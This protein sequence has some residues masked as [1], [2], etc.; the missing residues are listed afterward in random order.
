MATLSDWLCWQLADSAFP[1]GGFAHSNG[2]EALWKQGELADTEQLSL[3]LSQAL[4]Q[5]RHADLPVIASVMREPEQM[6]LADHQVQAMNLNAVASNASRLQGR[7]LLASA[8][9]AFDSPRLKA[10]SDT[11]R[12]S[13]SPRHLPVAFAVVAHCLGLVA[14][15]ALSLYLFMALRSMLSASVRLGIIGPLES[16]AV[17]YRFG[18]ECE[19]LASEALEC[20]LDDAHQPSPLMDLL[21][22]N[23]QR[24]Y[25]RLFQS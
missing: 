4:L 10:L 9:Q 15:R 2:I 5:L 17:I 18:S 25:S 11:L 21:H 7:A 23:H 13:G 3:F 6:A 12:Q 22:V 16:Q 14:E 1:S 20:K 8:E 19:W 24:L